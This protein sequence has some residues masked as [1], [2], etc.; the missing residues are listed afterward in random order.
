[1][2]HH[3]ADG[4]AE[5]GG[6]GD[7][8]AEGG[9]HHAEA[10]GTDC[11]ADD[12]LTGGDEQSGGQ[13]LQDAE[14]DQNVD[15]VGDGA[16]PGCDGEAGEGDEPQSSYA[17]ATSEPAAHRERDGERDQVAVGDPLGG[18]DARVQVASDR[19]EPDVDDRR[20]EAA[21]KGTEGDDCGQ[22]PRVHEKAP[23]QRHR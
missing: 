12:G 13:A 9:H 5:R 16:Q 15:V 14:A 22:A 3:S 7:R 8:G 1:M 11:L 18:A 21:H 2:D 19:F 17:D 4:R 20:V 10:V 6:E 23:H